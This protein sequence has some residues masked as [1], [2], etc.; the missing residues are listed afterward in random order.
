MKVGF[1]GL[2]KLGLPCALG[3]ESMGHTVFGVDPSPQTMDILECRKLAYEEVGAQKL[4]DE[5]KIHL[6][7]YAE[8]VRDAELIFIA[9]QTPH[10]PQYEGVT[11]MPNTRAD[12]NYE[13]LQS[14]FTSLCVEMV[15][16]GVERDVVVISTVLPGTMAKYIQPIIDANG[17]SRKLRLLYNPFFIAMGT[18]LRDFLNPEFVLI[19]GPCPA[20]TQR[21]ASFYQTIH[22]RPAFRTTVENAELIKVAYNVAIGGKIV[23]ANTIMEICHKTPN[24]DCDAVMAALSLATERIVSSRYLKG[25]MGDGGGC[26]PRDLIALSWLAQ[27]LDLSHDPFYDIMSAREDQTE[28]LADLIQYHAGLLPIALMGSAFK[29]NT[30]ITTGSPARLLSHYLT[31][32]NLEHKFIEPNQQL[33]SQPPS[34]FFVSTQH[35]AWLQYEFPEGSV[36]LDPFR[37]LQDNASLAKCTY[38]PIGKH[39]AVRRPDSV[40]G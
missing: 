32:R 37:Y 39:H 27:R 15:K 23:F 30:N 31:E 17:L 35:S 24:T 7:T 1:V 6:V 29:P 40:A 26:H 33:S 21:L 10:D 8:L 11:P 4:L 5:T 3:V 9:V 12:F 14:A 19:G 13:Y 2:G 18:A 25:G 36:V 34:L 38:I 20:T 16:Q 22:D 28:W